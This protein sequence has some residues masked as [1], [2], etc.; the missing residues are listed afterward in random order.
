MLRNDPQNAEARYLFGR[1]AMELGDPV[2]DGPRHDAGDQAVPSPYSASI[3]STNKPTMVKNRREYILL[4][5][6][7]KAR[8]DTI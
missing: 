6:G 8:H 7:L 3:Y 4:P 1:V 5:P 2:P